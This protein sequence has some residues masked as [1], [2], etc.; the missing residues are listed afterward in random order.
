MFFKVRATPAAI[1]EKGMLSGKRIERS[2]RGAPGE[3]DW[4]ENA[5]AEQL[6][7]FLQTGAKPEQPLQ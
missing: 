3:F 5:T 1:K 2:E 7:Q 6:E 4:I